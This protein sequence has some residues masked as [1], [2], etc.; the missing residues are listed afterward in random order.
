MDK[1]RPTACA[2]QTVTDERDEITRSPVWVNLDDYC[3]GQCHGACALR[4]VLLRET[5]KSR[6]R[7][8]CRADCLFESEPGLVAR[9]C[10]SL[11]FVA[12]IS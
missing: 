4:A 2:S 7:A 9:E 10:S 6:R 12:R 5:P 1:R 8:P 3:V 11:C